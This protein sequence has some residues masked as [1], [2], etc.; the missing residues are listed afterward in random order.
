MSL[1]H[2]TVA[3]R[4][5]PTVPLQYSYLVFHYGEFLTGF[6]LSLSLSR[7]ASTLL[8]FQTVTE[9]LPSQQ[10]FGVGNLCTIK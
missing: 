10:G 2:R 6:S 3:E 9:V 7:D 5:G 1:R 4:W 8:K